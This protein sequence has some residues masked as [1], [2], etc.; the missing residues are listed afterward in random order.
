MKKL[1]QRIPRSILLI[2]VINITIYLFVLLFSFIGVHLNDMFLGA[3]P[4]AS[5]NY[6]FH[7]IFTSMF[8]HSEYDESHIIV[9]L[10]IF[11]LFSFGVYRT[12]GNRGVYITY[13]ISGVVSSLIAMGYMSS[14]YVENIYYLKKVGIELTDQQLEKGPV[15]NEYIVENN[16]SKEQIRELDYYNHGASNLIG[17]SGAICGIMMVYLICNVL[18]RKKLLYNLLIFFFLATSI[19]YSYTFVHISSIAHLG[20]F[21]GGIMSF[22]LLR[23]QTVKKGK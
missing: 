12:Y 23:I 11:L 19:Y 21:I 22:I 8:T 18:S 4:F 15:S 2:L 9:N 3:Y 17:A 7:Q 13:I 16:F 14:Q 10:I 6:S 1:I 20:G 5:P